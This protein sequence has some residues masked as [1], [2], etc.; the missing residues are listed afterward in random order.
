MRLIRVGILHISYGKPDKMASVMIS[1]DCR[2]TPDSARRFMLKKITMVENGILCSSPHALHY[3]EKILFESDNPQRFGTR[4]WIKSIK[5][6]VIYEDVV[7]SLCAPC[8]P[9]MVLQK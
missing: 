1:V 3:V 4:K 7:D 8:L 6:K 2:S 5:E 9:P